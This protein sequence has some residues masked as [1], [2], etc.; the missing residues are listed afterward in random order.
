MIVLLSPAKTF[1]LRYGSN[2]EFRPLPDYAK[3]IPVTMPQFLGRAQSLATQLSQLSSG[4]L[5]HLMSLSVPL[6]ELNY[7]RYQK[8][9]KG[10]QEEYKASPN[11]LAALYA[12]G[13]DTYVG[14]DAEKSFN[15]GD[16]FYAQ[17]H[18]RILSGL[19][20]ILRPFDAIAPYRLEMS[21]SLSCG[22]AKNLYKNLYE[23]WKTSCMDEIKSWATESH[24]VIINA[25][26]QEYF[27][28][29]QGAMTDL[30]KI[31]PAIKLPQVITP[32]FK[33]KTPKAL[34]VVG[35]MAK[36][37]R[38]RFARHIIEHR[39]SDHHLLC[40]F[41]GLGYGYRKTYSSETEMVF[42]RQKPKPAVQRRWVYVGK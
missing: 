35:L 2:D 30:A 32:V 34:K 26:S 7:Q 9:P 21:T 18:L 16:A 11:T 14:L 39:I 1:K 22:D 42:T 6:S 10:S 15:A 13:G 12:F 25:A 5:G 41:N 36:K 27:K 17:E 20:G 19:Y 4:E 8:F 3:N 28:V 38:G 23:Y 33:E 40:E 29:I 37:A 31:D 24:K